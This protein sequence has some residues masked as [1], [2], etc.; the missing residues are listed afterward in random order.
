MA[1]LTTV[2]SHQPY[3]NSS[4]YGDLYRKYFEGE[5]YSKN[6]S[7]YL[8]KLKVVDNALGIMIDKLSEAKVLDDTVIVLLADHYPYGLNNSYI[9]EIIDYDLSDYDI[10][11]TPLVIYNPEMTPEEHTEYNSYINLVPTIA[12]LMNLDYDPRLYMGTDLFSES[13]ESRVVFADG[14]WK[15]EDAYYN[16]STGKIKYYGDIEYTEEEIKEINNNINL[17]ITISSK[18]IKNNYFNYLEK[19]LDEYNDKNKLVEEKSI[20]DIS[21]KND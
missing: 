9:K 17:K 8:S 2:T 21:N 18:A 5:G 10:E 3:N 6:V 20:D 7:R 13:Y 15:N 1:W 12:N 19:K 4:T 16:A 11:K 14:S